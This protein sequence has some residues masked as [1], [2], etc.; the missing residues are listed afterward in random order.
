MATKGMNVCIFSY[1]FL[2]YFSRIK[3]KLVIGDNIQPPVP[4]SVLH[5]KFFKCHSCWHHLTEKNS[6]NDLRTAANT[7]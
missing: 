4:L 7:P 2:Q 3:I 6:Q 1:I 5:G